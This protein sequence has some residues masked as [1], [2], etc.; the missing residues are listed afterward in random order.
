M[1]GVFIEVFIPCR[2]LRNYV[3]LASTRFSPPLGYY[4]RLSTG[5]NFSEFDGHTISTSIFVSL[6]QLSPFLHVLCSA[7]LVYHR[8]IFVSLAQFSSPVQMCFH[9][10]KA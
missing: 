6:S 4:N 9:K 5:F 10:R 7:H 3:I 2:G 1:L 8:A